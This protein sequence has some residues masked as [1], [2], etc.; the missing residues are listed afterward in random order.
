MI[1]T[2]IE[3]IHGLVIWKVVPDWVTQGNRNTRDII[4]LSP[5]SKVDSIIKLA[6]NII[7]I[8][9]VL[10]GCYS[11]VMALLGNL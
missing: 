5:L 3:I 1:S 6:C 4:K 10:A 11:L 9:I 7:G 8:F 2:I